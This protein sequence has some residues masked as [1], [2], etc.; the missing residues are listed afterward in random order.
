M[1]LDGHYSK[2][3]A[4]QQWLE[5]NHSLSAVTAADTHKREGEKRESERER[6]RL[7]NKIPMAK[8]PALQ[9]SN[10]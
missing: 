5:C 8:A 9:K 1:E 3:V 10:H 6:E 7:K 4:A 2:L